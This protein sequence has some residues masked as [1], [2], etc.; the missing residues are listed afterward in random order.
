[1]IFLLIKI[2]NPEVEFR[3][4]EYMIKMLKIRGY[5]LVTNDIKGLNE[6][7]LTSLDLS[8][9]NQSIQSI[10]INRGRLDIPNL[11]DGSKYTYI[12]FILNEDSGNINDHIKSILNQYEITTDRIDDIHLIFIDSNPKQLED[13]KRSYVSKYKGTFE[14]F[15]LRILSI[16]YMNHKYQSS[17]EHLKKGSDEHNSLIKRY[18]ISMKI[19]NRDDPVAKFYN[20][21]EGDIIKYDGVNYRRVK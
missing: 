3:A 4:Y 11:W 14:I 7:T 15:D 18:G 20:A 5:K 19:I 2:M 17:T 1:M 16:N 21:Q 10:E 9:L 12:K 6:P 13:I 8:S